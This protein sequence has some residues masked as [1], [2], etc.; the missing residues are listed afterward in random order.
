M[1]EQVEVVN[2]GA[3]DLSDI[4]QEVPEMDPNNP[5]AL[6]PVGPT[7][8]K[9]TAE[10]IPLITKL[11]G[12][13]F[14][15]RFSERIKQVAPDIFDHLDE[16]PDEGLEEKL[17]FCDTIIRMKSGSS[18]VSNMVS[19]MLTITAG[20]FTYAGYEG[21]NMV[22]AILQQDDNF[23]DI[24]EELKLKHSKITNI[25]PEYRLMFTVL[26]TYWTVAQA[27]ENKKNS[28]YNQEVKTEIEKPVN[29]PEK[30]ADL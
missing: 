11:S 14:S 29:N 27:T 20:A 10:R 18:I 3:P 1:D 8:Y 25:E 30:Y 22:P 9:L 19:P 17:R 6:G 12:Y 21:M 23:L 26:S 16:T 7:K 15:P 4:A 28:N 5:M 24:L 13:Q 2:T